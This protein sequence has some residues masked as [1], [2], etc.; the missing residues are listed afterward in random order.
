LNIS[1]EQV[2]AVV[3]VSTSLTSGIFWGAFLLGKLVNRVDRVEQVL[4]DHGLFGRRAVD[5]IQVDR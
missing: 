4:D 5:R 3:A 1:T 2:L